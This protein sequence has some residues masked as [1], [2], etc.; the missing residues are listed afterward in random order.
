MK[1]IASFAFE[2]KKKKKKYV[3]GMLY[4]GGWTRGRCN[5]KQER[6]D[7]EV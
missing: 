6:Q 3:I 2:G 5:L 7:I 4:R 1:A